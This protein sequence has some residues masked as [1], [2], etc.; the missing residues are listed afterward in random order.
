LYCN[1]AWADSILLL[2]SFQLEGVPLFVVSGHFQLQTQRFESS[3][4]YCMKHAMLKAE[5]CTSQPLRS[6]AAKDPGAGKPVSNPNGRMDLPQL[7]DPPVENDV[8][9]YF[10][11]E[12]SAVRRA[13]VKARSGTDSIR[14]TWDMLMAKV[15]IGWVNQS[16]SDVGGE[17]AENSPP[18]CASPFWPSPFQHQHLQHPNVY[19]V[20]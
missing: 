20:T 9:Y 14:T 5:G 8:W 18:F 11:G 6:V 19:S 12:A 15:E 13:Q 10:R 1:V 17:S 4:R 3:S 2:S 16:E 7:L